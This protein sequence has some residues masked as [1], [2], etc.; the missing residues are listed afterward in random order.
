MDAA[1]RCC[2]CR[3]WGTV[4][5]VCRTR[6]HTA[7]TGAREGRQTL[8]C[9]DVVGCGKLCCVVEP[10]LP[11]E[12][13][14]GGQGL[15]HSGC[16]DVGVGK[17]LCIAGWRACGSTVSCM[18]PCSTA[19]LLGWPGP[20]RFPCPI[21]LCAYRSCSSMQLVGQGFWPCFCRG[22]CRGACCLGWPGCVPGTYTSYTSVV[23]GCRCWDL[24]CKGFE[25]I[26]LIA[27]NSTGGGSLLCAL[28]CCH[29]T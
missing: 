3:Q 24:F 12:W 28:P 14:V 22:S 4:R 16:T 19:S 6:M 11:F 2:S 20:L 8:R 18:Q 1:S 5:M 7:L 15:Q 25:N 23:F 29:S 10:A 17:Y 21:G 13:L 27:S 26:L 9:W